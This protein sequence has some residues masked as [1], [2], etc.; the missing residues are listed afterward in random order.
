MPPVAP[1]P[2]MH[3]MMHHLNSLN[4]TSVVRLLLN[5]Q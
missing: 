2:I 4:Q 5:M 3:G 1:Q